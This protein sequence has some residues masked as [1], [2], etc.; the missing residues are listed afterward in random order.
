MFINNFQASA[1]ILLSGNNYEKVRLFVKFLGLK[2]PSQTSFHRVQNKY[3][4]PV[5]NQY[6]S[7]LRASVAEKHR[8]VSIVV[9]G[10]GRMDSPG[11]CAKYCTY[12][13]MNQEDK[14]ILALEVVDKRETD[15]KSGLMEAKGF[16]KAMATLQADGIELKEIVTDAHPKISAIMRKS[17]P[18]I[19]HSY[20]MWHG[21]KNLGKKL[22]S[23]ALAKGNEALKPWLK[24]ITNHF[25]HSAETC[26]GNALEMKTKWLSVINHVTNRHTW[27][28]GQC[29]HEPIVED[30]RDLEEKQWLKPASMAVK[31]LQKTVMEPRL[32]KTFP[33]YVTCQTTSELE[34]FNNHLLMYAPKRNAFGYAGYKCRCQ[35]AAI[36]YTHHVD[37][38]TLVDK[39]GK[40][41][42]RRVHS[43]AANNWMVVPV[44]E[45]KQYKYILGLLSRICMEYIQIN[46]ENP[47]RSKFRVDPDD[48]KKIAS[49]IAQCPPPPTAELR[50]TKR[51]RIKV[52]QASKKFAD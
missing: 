31:D 41:R 39:D 17:Y 25:F 32:L 46:K 15:L 8:A 35:L 27:A 22:S 33:Y 50:E 11:Y 3:A 10:D 38:Q 49:T 19:W 52:K 4:V 6:W 23:I 7:D 34:M 12:T 28:L 37:R 40:T 44:K 43:K 24:D 20:D 2:F 42:V 16:A 29:D 26:G 13:V 14:K 47:L 48:P 18:K 36:D 51:S 5:V 9:S 1:S 21:A 45:K 30:E